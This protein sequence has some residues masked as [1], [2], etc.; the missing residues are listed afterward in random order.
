MLYVWFEASIGYISATKEWNADKWKDYWCDPETL[1]VQFIGKDNIPFHAAIFPAMT[2]GQNQPYK[3][4]DDLPAN[5]FYNLEGKQFSKSEGWYIDLAD[6][7]TR[8]TPDQ[9][10]YTLASNAPETADSSLPGKTFKAAVTQIFSAN[11]ATLF[12]ALSSLYKIT[13][14][15]KIPPLGQA[16]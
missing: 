1:L 9:L 11:L 6:F 14:Q 10:R 7:L 15:A 4:V 5:E 3:I 8:Y 16:R 12:T 13:A 2:M